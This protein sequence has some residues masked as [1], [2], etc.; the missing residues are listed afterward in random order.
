MPRAPRRARRCRAVGPSVF[1]RF[2]PLLR[3]KGTDLHKLHIGDS[4]TP[5]PYALALDVGF[6][7]SHP[8]WFQY[9]AT[10]G[11]GRL[12]RALREVH[13]REHR[14][15][16]ADGEILVCAG[17]THGLSAIVQTLVEANEEVLVPTPA[18]PFFRGMV[19]VAGG[20]VREL[21][22]YDRIGHADFDPVAALAAA[23]TERTVAVYLNSPNNPSGR[24]LD[25]A[26]RAAIL[27][28]AHKHDLWVIAD[29]AYDGLTFAESQPPPFGALRPDHENILSV[30]TFSK[31]H[32]LAGLRLG[33][34]RGPAS[35]LEAVRSIAIHQIYSASTLAQD[36]V[37]DAVRSRSA[38][39]PRVR[40]ALH[41]RRD[42]F[43]EALDLEI[44]APGGTYFCFF[45]LRPFVGDRTEEVVHRCL[46]SGIGVAPGADFGDHYRDWLRLCFAAETEQRA[47][48]AARRL[49]RIVREIART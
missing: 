17:G 29:E 45:D 16:A 46:E 4:A 43:L 11:T 19:R 5:P 49:G 40:A 33:W 22:F 1:E 30:F 7:E 20:V 28:F 25:D 27:E 15:P 2:L 37:L 31:L 36:L 10:A 9:P 47:L 38:W 32:L 18:W 35:V 26:L 24:V 6:R 14:W 34:V 8:H 3:E 39:A 44:E 23:T 12:R 13:R 41:E 21:P 42:R 48:D